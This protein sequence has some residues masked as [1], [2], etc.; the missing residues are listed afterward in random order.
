MK[1]IQL[2]IIGIFVATVLI[3]TTLY[4]TLSNE[5]VV[6]SEFEY[7][8]YEILNF[9]SYDDLSTYLQSSSESNN[10]GLPI[11]LD[12]NEVNV[13]RV[14]FLDEV[15]TDDQSWEGA[16]GDYSDTNIQELGVD[17]PDVIKTDGKYIYVISNQKLYIIYAY[18]AEDAEIISTIEFNESVYPTNLFINEDKLAVITQSYNY[19]VYD[20][21]VIEEK[22]EEIW[23]DTTLTHINIYDI[24]D[25]STPVQIREIDIEGYY[26]NA[27]MIDNY[28]Y[29]ITTQ[30]D[31]GPILLEQE[32]SYTPKIRVDEKAQDVGLSNIY[33]I[34]SPEKSETMTNIVSVNIQD[35]TEEVKIEIFLIGNPSTIYVSTENIYITSI[36]YSYDYTTIRDLIDQYVLPVL[37]IEAKN[38]INAVESLTLDEYQ[39]ASVVD[40]IIQNYVE[41]MDEQ[42]KLE[43]AKQLISQYEK[44]IIHKLK[45]DNGQ[46]TYLSQGTVPGYINNQFSISEYDRNLRVATTVN[47]WMVKSYLSS[48]DSYNNVFV[49]NEDLEIIGSIENIAVGEQIFSA[50]FLEDKCYLITFEQID[51]FF[52]ID[53]KD[54]ENPRILGELK[55]P[56]FSTYL[57][58]YD[59]NHVI[60]IGKEEQDVKISLFNVDDVSNPIELSTYKIQNDKEEYSWSYSA[61]LYEHKAFLFDLD[62]NLLIIP[63][64]IDYKESAYVF[65]VNSEKEII[66]KGVITHKSE[67][68]PAEDKEPWESSYWIGDYSYSII[69]SLYIDN[70]IYT[71]SNAMI[72]MNDMDDLSELNSLSFP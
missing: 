8:E 21:D 28:V 38:E 2:K 48:I 39:K 6:D 44:T 50:R 51:P 12:L 37:P 68:P 46:I 42:Q 10:N 1:T 3:T 33:Y 13:P 14:E 49:L 58:P 24:F 9:E 22:S 5:S 63:V 20:Y 41:N 67:D 40:W 29:V 71:L 11:S 66:L 25:K 72:M 19:R 34:D 61:A 62:K 69:R 47:G 4:Y 23:Q 55:I 59:E 57:H 16:S 70:V 45:I 27:R 17:E 53:L 43:I 35:E 18:P 54:P 65:N 56:G 15:S 52:V 30:Y 60:G 64:S 36:S 32:S 7:P 26:N 31:Y